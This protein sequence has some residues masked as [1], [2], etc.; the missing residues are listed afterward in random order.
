M[1]IPGWAIKGGTFV[2][3]LLLMIN[4]YFINRLV[5]YMDGVGAQVSTLTRQVDILSYKVDNIRGNK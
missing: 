3:S 4:G 2:I 1:T 5:N